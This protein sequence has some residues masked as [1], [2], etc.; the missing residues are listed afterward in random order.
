MLLTFESLLVARVYKVFL[1]RSKWLQTSLAASGPW[2]TMAAI[3]FRQARAILF[4]DKGE[5]G[6]Q[7]DRSTK[8]PP[9][10]PRVHGALIKPWSSRCGTMGLAASLQRQ[11]AG[12]IPGLAQCIKRSGMNSTHCGVAKKLKTSK[13][14]KKLSPRRSSKNTGYKVQRRRQSVSSQHH[15]AGSASPCFAGPRPGVAEHLQIL[16][17]VEVLERQHFMTAKAPTHMHLAF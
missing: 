11:D 5:T 16:G 10:Q 8:T 9:H 4:G 2:V 17:T 14:A 12:S 13:T 7:D 1:F 15:G 6:P 3:R